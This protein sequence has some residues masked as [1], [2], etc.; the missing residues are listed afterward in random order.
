MA[1]PNNLFHLHRK[2][3]G[4]ELH[5]YL[6]LLGHAKGFH[7][8]ATLENSNLME[9]AGI[10]RAKTFRDARMS[11]MTKHRI[12]RFI[13][14]DSRKTIYRY[15]LLDQPMSE[16]ECLSATTKHMK[17][18]L[19]D[20][21]EWGREQEMPDSLP[22]PSPAKAASRVEEIKPASK[23]EPTPTPKP[24]SAPWKVIITPSPVSRPKYQPLT[25]EREAER[26]K[27]LEERKQEMQQRLEEKEKER[28]TETEK[29]RP[30]TGTLFR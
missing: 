30:K 14:K 6:A 19:D 27:M 8:Y 10:T 23:P 24:A 4:P 20:D 21:D 18:S 2:M 17:T 26:E 1:C 7:R 25:P 16:M 29:L 12:V 5:L 9:L 13:P 15:E 11:L 3:S 22:S 28:R